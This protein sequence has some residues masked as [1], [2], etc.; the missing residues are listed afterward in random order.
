MLQVKIKKKTGKFS[1]G[2]GFFDGWRCIC[3]PGSIRMWKKYDVKNVS[4][5]S[6]RPNEGRIVLNDRVLFDSEKRINLPPQKRKVGYMFQDYALFPN[7]N[8]VQNIQAGMGR[9][10]GSEESQRVYHRISAWRTGKSH[11]GSALRRTKTACGDGTYAGFGA[12]SAASG[13]TVLL[14][15]TAI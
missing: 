11:A 6:K 13:R 14:R 3:H 4:Q 8:V 7:M 15:W 10:A 2:C 1:A 12:G 5:G 9:K